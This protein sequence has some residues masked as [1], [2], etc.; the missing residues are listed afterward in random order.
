M[1]M[2]IEED[3]ISPS[4]TL[5]E[6]FYILS[7]KNS[8]YRV[9]LSEKGLC[10]Q[11]EY[12]GNVKNET[13]ALEDIIGCRCMRS[14]RFAQK[15]MWHPTSSKK[16]LKVVDENSME[17]DETDVSAYLYIYAYIIK[18]GKVKSNKK[19]ERMVITLRFRSYDKYED[20]M[21]EAQKWKVTIKYY[22]NTH[23]K[24]S[25]PS[26][27]F[28]SSDVKIDNKILVIL[29]PK[30]GVG[31]A[32]EVFQNK[33]VPLLTEADINYDLH[34]TRHAHDARNLTR[35]QNMW[36]YMGGVV[37]IGGD[38]ILHEVINGLM[39][40]PD[41]ENLFQ[42]LK[43]GI[44]PSGSGN[45]LAKS[46]SYAF[47]E[48]YDQSPTLVSALN[49][50]RGVSTP[51]DLVRVETKTQVLFSFLSVGWGLLSDVDIESERIRALGSQRFTVW[52]V[53]K[54]IG[55]RS[56]KGTVSYLPVKN[57]KA[58][59]ITSDEDNENR[60]VMSEEGRRDSF[61]SV[62]SRRSTYLSAAGSSYES[63]SD[64]AVHTFGPP[65]N[66][67]PLGQPLPP[68][69]VIVKGE[70]VLVHASYPTH[71]MTDCIFAPS[72][73]LDDGCIWLCVI[74]S[75][76]SRAHLVQFLLGMSNGTHTTVPQIDFLPVSAFRIEPEPNYGGHITV[77]GELIEFGPLQA[78]ILPSLANVF[79]R[80]H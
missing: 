56:Y 12:N 3:C 20:N 5:E 45:G 21:R 52:T 72:A 40:R 2:E 42:D 39:E 71:L 55:L 44:I 49:I 74:K 69:W 10:L 19:R 78:E 17:W 37:V 47:N 16:Y 27:Y 48:P 35:T 30:S 14:K 23:L 59:S 31:K 22:M 53:A 61:Y 46:I 76:I 77:D 7:K 65:S 75:G 6:T 4:P 67:P 38:G 24:T 34:V 8:V 13:I 50:V 62:G 57:E 63:L 79:A 54:L 29:N 60:S 9:K 43:L 28:T 32:R 26:C 33:V 1:N 80:A 66:L 36:Q 51:L 41:W 25:L 68:D 64:D 70:F 18:K 73:K 58:C 11:K 15:C